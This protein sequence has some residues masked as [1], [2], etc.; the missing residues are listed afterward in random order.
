MKP[1]RSFSSNLDAVKNIA[2]KDTRFVIIKVAQDIFAK[3]GYK[4][5]TVHD[6]AR[7]A[8]KVKSTIYQ[9]FK[10]K[11]EIFQTVVEKESQVLKEEIK[12]VINLQDDP[13]KKLFSYVITRMRVLEDLPNFYNALRDEHL[14]HFVFIEKMRKKYLK[15]E[16]DTV[17]KIL[18]NGVYQGAF[19]INDLK[20]TACMIVVALKGLEHPLIA[21][22]RMLNTNQS[23]SGLLGIL[24]SGIDKR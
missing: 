13:K 8:H 24:F 19:A 2:L 10:S 11:E 18:K 9:Y 7:A 3:F 12:K 21:E 1:K 5:T 6:I 22:S 16:I 20:L 14:D 4:K 15:H 17:T 23:I